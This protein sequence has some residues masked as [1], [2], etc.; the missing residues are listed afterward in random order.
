MDA[1]DNGFGPNPVNVVAALVVVSKGTSQ[2]RPRNPSR[3]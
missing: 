1:H 3:Q 2:N